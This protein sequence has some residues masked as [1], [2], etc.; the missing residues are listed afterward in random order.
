M[1]TVILTFFIA[2]LQNDST[3]DAEDERE[4]HVAVASEAIVDHSKVLFRS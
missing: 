1:A 2:L 4:L 3:A